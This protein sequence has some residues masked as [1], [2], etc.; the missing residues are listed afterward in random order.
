MGQEKN[1]KNAHILTVNIAVL[2]TLSDQFHSPPLLSI[3]IQAPI[4]HLSHQLYA[5]YHNP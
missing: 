4:H 5:C 2:P 1:Y 3:Q